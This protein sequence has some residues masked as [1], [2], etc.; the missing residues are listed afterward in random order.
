MKER[1]IERRRDFKI[2]VDLKAV[3]KISIY[4]KL[5]IRD[6]AQFLGRWEG[7][8]CGARLGSRTQLKRWENAFFH[9]SLIMLYDSLCLVKIKI[10][11]TCFTALELIM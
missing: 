7:E 5:R 9:R 1:R 10:V 2:L 3:E 6:L 11:F 4:K 8:L